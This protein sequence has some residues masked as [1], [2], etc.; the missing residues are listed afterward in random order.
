MSLALDEIEFACEKPN[1]EL[2]SNDVGNW[3]HKSSSIQVFTD[4][5]MEK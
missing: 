3:M 2:N 1:K 5:Q 4:R